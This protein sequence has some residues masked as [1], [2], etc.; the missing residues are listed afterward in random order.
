VADEIRLRAQLSFANSGRS[1][2]ADS[3]ELSLS[4]TGT[5]SHRTIQTVGTAEEA[6]GLGEVGAVNT[7][8]W[9]RNLDA[10]NPVDL[11]PATGGTVTTRIVAGRVATGQFGPGVTAPFVQASGAPVDIDVFLVQA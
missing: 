9:I 8:Y 7:H 5:K 11:K 1:G 10:T 6:L 2:A 4:M 3:G